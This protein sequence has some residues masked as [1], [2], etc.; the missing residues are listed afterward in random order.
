[1]ALI[2]EFYIGCSGW[3]YSGWIVIFYPKDM[4]SKDYLSYYSKFFNFIEVDL[5]YYNFPS[6]FTVRAWKDK[7]PSVFHELCLNSMAILL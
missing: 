4:G 6:K 5:T 1:M 2:I 3:N 7:T